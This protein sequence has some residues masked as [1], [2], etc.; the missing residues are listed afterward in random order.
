LLLAEQTNPQQYRCDPEGRHAGDFSGHDTNKSNKLEC[1]CFSFITM[2]RRER[3]LGS[4]QI[5][6]GLAAGTRTRNGLSFRAELDGAHIPRRPGG[7][8]QRLCS[9]PD[10]PARVSG[11]IQLLHA[12]WR[13]LTELF[14][15]V[16]L[17]FAGSFCSS[18]TADLIHTERPPWRP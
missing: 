8:P 5:I 11:K 16:P 7:L 9:H 2:N 12:L 13:N 1:R 15:S 10:R 14:V 3:S 4:D 17:H 18:R 6:V